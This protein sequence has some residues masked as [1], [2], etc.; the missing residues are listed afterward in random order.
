ME[1]PYRNR[2]LIR[3]ILQTVNPE[4]FLGIAWDITGTAEKIRTHR[5]AEWKANPVTDES[6]D[7]KPA[8]FILGSL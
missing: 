5:I 1:T 6:A 2:E 7:Q 3:E 4:L 8:V